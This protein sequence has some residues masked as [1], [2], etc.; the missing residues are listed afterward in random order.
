MLIGICI[1]CRWKT[2]NLSLTREVEWEQ[3]MNIFSLTDGAMFHFHSKGGLQNKCRTILCVWSDNH[4]ANSLQVLAVN[5]L[6]NGLHPHSSFQPTRFSLYCFTS[7]HYP[8]LSPLPTA[9]HIHS[10]QG[11]CGN[12]RDRSLNPPQTR[13]LSAHVKHHLQSIYTAKFG[14]YGTDGSIVFWVHITSG[15]FSCVLLACGW[16]GWAAAVRWTMRQSSHWSCSLSFQTAI[17]T[18]PRASAIKAITSHQQC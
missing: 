3:C 11:R 13:A 12:T 6:C 4:R 16:Q 5:Q 1:S 10:K 2:K 7:S 17:S 8:S 9:S 15:S 18:N 14:F